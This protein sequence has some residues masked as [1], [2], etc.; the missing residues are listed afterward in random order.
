MQLDLLLVWPGAGNGGSFVP[1]LLF[2]QGNLVALHNWTE[3]LINIPELSVTVE[4]WW[5]LSLQTTGPQDRGRVAA[6]LI[7]TAW[8]VWNERNRCIFTG[9][10][11]SPT[12]LLS[13]IKER[14]KWEGVRVCGPRGL[15]V[16]HIY[17]CFN[18][19]SVFIYYVI[20]KIVSSN[21]LLL[22]WSGSAPTIS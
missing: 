12:R 20:A 19:A 10:S 7:Y 4:D 6:I 18:G 11:I 9:V 14:W 16:F 22:I 1:A 2:R 8:N 13:M 15:L 21:F 3:D 17:L 5:N